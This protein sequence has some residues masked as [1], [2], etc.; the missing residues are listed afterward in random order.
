MGIGRIRRKEEALGGTSL[1]AM[2]RECHLRLLAEDQTAASAKCK[3]VAGFR[4]S[5]DK[6][7]I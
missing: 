3:M 7:S 5:P 6:I 2:T 1:L 4:R